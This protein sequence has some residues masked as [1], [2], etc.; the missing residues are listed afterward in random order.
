MSDK[1]NVCILFIVMSDSDDADPVIDSK[2]VKMVI[3]KTVAT[4]PISI[5]IESL[6]KNLCTMIE[7]DEKRAVKIY[8]IICSKLHEMKLIDESY[9]MTEFEGMRHQY[10][11]ALYRLVKAARGGE[12]IPKLIERIWADDVLHLSRYHKE[13]EEINFIAG[14]GFGQVS[15]KIKI[16][17]I[18]SI[19]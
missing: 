19:D 3:R 6:V 13:F 14:G 7:T 9:R 8:N 12:E 15:I 17:T 16:F 5:L 10:E 4:T 1:I 2:V 18:F 11:R